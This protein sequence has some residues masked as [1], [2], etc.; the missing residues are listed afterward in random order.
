MTT[1]KPKF[2]LISSFPIA[3]ACEGC[4]DQLHSRDAH[5]F[6]RN[7]LWELV[8][9]ERFRPLEAVLKQYVFAAFARRHAKRAARWNGVL[10]NGAHG[11][12]NG[13]QKEPQ[14][15]RAL[16]LD[17]RPELVHFQA[18]LLLCLVI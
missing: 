16:D 11:S 18:G 2:L 6:R 12:V 13:A 7:S 5:S 9:L 1:P 10:R 3:L 14:V 15:D 8:A 4:G 17:Q